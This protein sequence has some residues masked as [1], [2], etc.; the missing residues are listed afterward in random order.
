VRQETDADFERDRQLARDRI[1]PLRFP[2][3][4]RGDSDDANRNQLV[5]SETVSNSTS[6]RDCRGDCRWF[7]HCRG[8]LMTLATIK[9]N[10]DA[11]VGCRL[12]GLWRVSATA[13][14]DRGE[15]AKR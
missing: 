5:T 15:H 12:D 8:H 10:W 9:T 2:L 6:D 13:L 4:A 7:T 14:A 1:A 3:K 11:D